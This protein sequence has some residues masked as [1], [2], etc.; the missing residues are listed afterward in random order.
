VGKYWLIDDTYNANPFSLESAIK[1]LDMMNI[2]GKRIAVCGDMLELGKRSKA[3]HQSAGKMIA[4]SY[5]DVVLTMG[6]HMRY[7]TEILNK[8]AKNKKGIHCPEINDV[9]RWLKRICV[10]GDAILVKGSR[11]LRLERT[12]AFLKKGLK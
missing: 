9:H 3:L 8:T 6:K 12:V 1:T 5:T 2:R 7:T 4:L 10:P 11:G